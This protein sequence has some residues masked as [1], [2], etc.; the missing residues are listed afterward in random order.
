[1][2]Y[3]GI[4]YSRALLRSNVINIWW[5]WCLKCIGN[6]CSS[7]SMNLSQWQ[8]TTL[9]CIKS[10][11]SRDSSIVRFQMPISSMKC[12]SLLILL[13]G[14]WLNC[15]VN[16]EGKWRHDEKQIWMEHKMA[17][18]IS[19]RMTRSV[20]SVATHVVIRL[21]MQGNVILPCIWW[22][23]TS[24]NWLRARGPW[25]QVWILLHLQ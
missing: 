24:I 21:T 16:G 19:W 11:K 17:K 18:V 13:W 1:M 12:V 7:D 14:F 4:W 9:M 5:W 20:A 25:E 6:G 23:C 8:H 22:I 3:K 15:F 2:I 10:T